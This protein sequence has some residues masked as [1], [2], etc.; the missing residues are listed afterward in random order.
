MIKILTHKEMSA[1]QK[2]NIIDLWKLL[3]IYIDFCAAIQNLKNFSQHGIISLFC[4][5]M[6]IEGS[7]VVYRRDFCFLNFLIGG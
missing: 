3:I 1:Y 7:H 4:V 2:R 5:G 6:Y